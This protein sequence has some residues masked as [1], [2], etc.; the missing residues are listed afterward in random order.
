[1]EGLGITGFVSHL[2]SRSHSSSKFEIDSEFGSLEL[3]DFLDSLQLFSHSSL[4]A[5]IPFWISGSKI[6][7]F[8]SAGLFEV[9]THEK[10]VRNLPIRNRVCVIRTCVKAQSS[11]TS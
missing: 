10:G 11:S 2:L 7:S 9:I 4:K 8:G 5:S 3:A 6:S 1:M